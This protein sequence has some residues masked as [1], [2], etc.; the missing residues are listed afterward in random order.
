MNKPINK[1]DIEIKKNSF[2]LS[3]VEWLYD[4]FHIW[5]MTN[6]NMDRNYNFRY[7][8]I[9]LLTQLSINDVRMIIVRER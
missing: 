5:Q 4:K 2:R 6:L 3:H 8:M 7:E 9:Y 1:S